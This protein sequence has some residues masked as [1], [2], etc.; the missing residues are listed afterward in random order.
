M[1]FW[2]TIS[3]EFLNRWPEIKVL[4]PDKTLAQLSEVKN[5]ELAKAVNQLKNWF[6][7]KSCKS[8]WS[9]LNLL[10]KLITKMIGNKAKGTQIKEKIESGLL[11]TKNGKL[12][13]IR[14]ST[15]AA[16]EAAPP[17]IQS[18][19]KV[20]A[21][22]ECEAK[23]S[24]MVSKSTATRTS[25]TNVQYA[26]ALEDCIGPI[27]QFFDTTV[28]GG[29][30]DPHLGGMLNV[31]SY[32]TG[33]NQS[34]LTWKQATSNFMDKHLNP[35][36]S[37]LG[38]VFTKDDRKK[39]TLDYV[40]PAEQEETS[41]HEETMALPM[42]DASTL[43]QVPLSSPGVPESLLPFDLP[44]PSHLDLQGFD[45]P[46]S[47]VFDA[48]LLSQ[49]PLSS[50]PWPQ[51]PT[52]PAFPSISLLPTTSLPDNPITSWRKESK[53]WNPTRISTLTTS[54]TT[55]LTILPT[56]NFYGHSFPTPGIVPHPIATDLLSDDSVICPTTTAG[57]LTAVTNVD[58]ITLDA[59]TAPASTTSH[60][61]SAAMVQGN[62][63]ELTAM[64]TTTMDAPT[65]QVG[66]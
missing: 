6:N 3:M 22:K 39:H 1:N 13:A 48:S 24:A 61:H 49:Q 2:A 42:S 58:L 65:V 52:L 16:Y 17:E 12:M 23:A 64:D 28:I 60:V 20:K 41:L 46:Y 8:G 45:D 18:L 53:F 56:F 32:H 47:W 38:T 37:Y 44:G 29:G 10:I 4:Y 34:S 35:Y 33:M 14:E 15:K 11:M 62:A 7:Y 43:L 26:K 55:P 19:C 25:P 36:L 21:A 51:T 63:I 50:G 30:L 31:S 54:P 66:V 9:Q 59:P 40:S 27:S 5:V 57:Q